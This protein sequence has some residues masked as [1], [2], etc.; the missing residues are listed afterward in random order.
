MKTIF[1]LIAILVAGCAKDS[2]NDQSAPAAAPKINSFWEDIDNQAVLD[3]RGLDTS[4]F[5]GPIAISNIGGCNCNATFSNGTF[6][7][8]SCTSSAHYCSYL[9]NKTGTY[10]MSGASISICPSGGTCAN[11]TYFSDSQ[12]GFAAP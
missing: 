11:Y 5:A 7:I 10:Q 12:V 2:T 9:W 4:T 6:S 8:S 3:L 1:V